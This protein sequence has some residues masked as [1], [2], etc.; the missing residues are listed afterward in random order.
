MA[1]NDFDSVGQVL[2][3]DFT[4]EWPQSHERIRG[5][6]NFARMNAQY[7]A[8]GRW[9]FTVN[10]IVGSGNEAVSDVSVTDG[11]VRARAISFFTMS[12][13]KISH[14][15]EFWPD[16]YPAPANRRHLVEPMA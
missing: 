9:Q 1:T 7:P 14:I 12:E 13:G 6:I 16:D 2:S 8:K 10:R 15:V 11:H 3:K 5:A 4:L